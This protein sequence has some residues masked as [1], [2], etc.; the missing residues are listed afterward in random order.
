[1]IAYERSL[2]PNVVKPLHLGVE[3]FWRSNLYGS[4][5][6]MFVRVFSCWHREMG[7]PIT[8]DGKTYRACC[9][10]GMRRDFDLKTWRTTG[11]YYSAHPN[12]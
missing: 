2:N 9:A 3:S 8:H 1:M 10:C 6:Y 5:R 7:R 4:L 12:Q 11:P